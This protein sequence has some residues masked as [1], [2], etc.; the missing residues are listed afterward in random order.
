MGGEDVAVD[1]DFRAALP[2]VELLEFEPMAH[3]TTFRIGGPA[4]WMFLP[5]TAAQAGQVLALCYA[6][7]VQPFFLGNGSNLLV[8]DAGYGGVILS[9]AKLEQNLSVEDDTAIVADSGVLLARLANFAADRGLSGLEFAS[10]IPGSLG[11]AVRMNAGAYGGE[12]SQVLERVDYL[13]ETGTL[14]SVTSAQC[15][16]SYRRSV[17]CKKPWLI[18]GALLRL[19]RGEVP[20]IRGEMAELNRRRREKQPLEYPSAGSTFKRPQEYFA[21]ALIEECGLK[22][23][24]VGGA[25]VS[26]KHS[27]FVINRGGATC[28]D[29]LSLMDQV[30]SRVRNKTGVT[31]EPEV[32]ILE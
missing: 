3:H 15:D 20:E 17:F 12:M 22:G 5:R 24:Q 19:K 13:D 21:A 27:G 16:F 9:T 11:G 26:E 6:Q 14:H 2:Q 1:I 31:L 32:E 23:F 7:G 8:S 4:R 10:G 25:Q 30:K 18:T 29:V 28:A